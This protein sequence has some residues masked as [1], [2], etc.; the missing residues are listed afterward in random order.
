MNTP[1]KRYKRGRVL[2]ATMF[3]AV[4]RPL[5]WLGR[6]MPGRKSVTSGKRDRMLVVQ[7]GALGDLVMSLPA[8][9]ALRAGYPAARITLVTGPWAQAVLAA[10]NVVDEVVTLSA[11]WLPGTRLR[12]GM[13]FWAGALSL[14]RRHFDL[15]LDLR[16]DPR[17][18]VFLYLTGAVER[19]SYGSYGARLG[20]YLLTDVVPGSVADVHLV[21][22][23][24]AVAAHLGCQ[25]ESRQP[26]IQIT[27]AERK[28]AQRWRVER[29]GG[30]GTVR[31][32]GIHP[33]AANPLRRWR[34]ER[35]LALIQRL[36]EDPDVRVVLFAGPAE[37]AMVAE[38]AQR[39]GDSVI[40]EALPLRSFITT[41]SA[42]DVLVAPD[43]APAHIVAAVGVPIVTLWGPTLPAFASPAAPAVIT[44]Q[45]GDFECRP[46]T[47]TRCVH[48]EASCMDAISVELVAAA[49]REA[50][51]ARV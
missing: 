27:P 46:C 41:A 28:E 34:T 22:A 37:E 43:S 44:L 39:A 1:L 7:T 49:T 18:L 8:L 2:A 12:D 33:G 26:H 50:L 19:V 35:W 9:A 16:G 51:A 17:S 48:P 11:P 4:A 36:C 15:G 42:L 38:I 6:H 40:M 29:A 30:V 20:D 14:R 24:L 25:A 47:Q 10:E 5:F 21:D 23:Y 31:V 13:R 45:V 32:V 3:D